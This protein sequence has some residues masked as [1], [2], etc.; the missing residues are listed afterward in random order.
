MT[1]KN[2][3]YDLRRVDFIPLPNFHAVIVSIA[4]FK[5]KPQLKLRVEGWLKFCTGWIDGLKP[6]GGS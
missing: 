4:K 3:H 5:S 1:S 2:P 6:V